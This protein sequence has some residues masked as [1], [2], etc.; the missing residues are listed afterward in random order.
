[1]RKLGTFSTHSFSYGTFKLKDTR[2][3]VFIS[4]DDIDF[5]LCLFFL[6]PALY[7]VPTSME[8]KKFTAVDRYNIT[9]ITKSAYVFKNKTRGKRKIY[10]QVYTY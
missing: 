7:T 8:S 9:I 5:I 1:M 10:K 4:T 6:P 3:A 2:V